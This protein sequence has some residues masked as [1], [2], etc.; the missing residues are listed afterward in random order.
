MRAHAQ[1]SG[2]PIRFSQGQMIPAQQP[3]HLKLTK[4]TD[5]YE[6]RCIKFPDRGCFHCYAEFIHA[7]LLE[8][9]A[10]V[11][12]FVPQPYQMIVN[13]R[14]YIPDVY[15]VRDSHIQVLELKPRGEFEPDKEQPLRAFFDQY[16]IGIDVL[17]N[18]TVL[19]QDRL[20][21]NWLPLVQVMAQALYQG[22]DTMHAEQRLWAIARDE[23]A[24]AVGDLLGD[25]PRDG[26]YW[27]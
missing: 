8:A 2:F 12:S 9:D 13:R 20:A 23:T 27:T 16:G 6:Q 25:G 22:L 11:T 24:I 1:K 18:E 19:E 4:R 17:A 3:T 15:F 21:L 7:L 14:P 26:R 10:A 5:Y